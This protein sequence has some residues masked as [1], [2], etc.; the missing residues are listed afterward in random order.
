MFLA[1]TQKKIQTEDDT[2]NKNKNLPESSAKKKEI[3]P[4]AISPLMT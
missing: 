1:G 3:S 2:N 4:Q